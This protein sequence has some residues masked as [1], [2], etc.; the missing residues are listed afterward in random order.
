[1]SATLATV[2]TQ[3][4]HAA[5]KADDEQWFA[6]PVLGIQGE[7][8]ADEPPLELRNCARCGSTLARPVLDLTRTLVEAA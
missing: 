4:S 7:W 6:L 8:Y 5:L 3:E 2:C 1:V